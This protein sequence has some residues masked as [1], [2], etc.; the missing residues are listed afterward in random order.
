M[1]LLISNPLGKPI[2]KE[3]LQTAWSGNSH[4]GG[5][6]YV[7][8]NTLIIEKGFFV[9]EEFYEAYTKTM[10]CPSICHMRWATSGEKNK[11]NCHPFVVSVDENN[12]VNLAMAHNGVVHAF[13]YKTKDMSDTF[14]FTKEILT[15]LAEDSKDLNWFKNPGLK[16]L[17]ENAIGSG[18][19]LA[20][21]DNT[22]HIEIFNQDSGEWLNEEYKIWASNGSYHTPKQRVSSG[23]S[24]AGTGYT[25]QAWGGYESDYWK[26]LDNTAQ[27][28]TGIS[29]Q[30]S[31]LNPVNIFEIEQEELDEIDDYL[32]ELNNANC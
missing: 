3:Q 26:N 21:I 9:F 16:Y 8:Q 10:D 27:L 32:D 23:Y 5:F 19:K 15:P 2:E 1:C 31:N 20:L 29:T 18:N 30:N 11:E 14:S 17:I 4:G 22:G 13:S 12:E 25:Q 7:K 28:E 6:A 24:A